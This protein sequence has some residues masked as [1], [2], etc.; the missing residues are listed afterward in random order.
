M[1]K[2]P[3]EGLDDSEFPP[4]LSGWEDW[5]R[6]ER[7]AMSGEGFDERGDVSGDIVPLSLSSWPLDSTFSDDKEM[8][9]IEVYDTITL[10]LTV[11]SDVK[12]RRS[13]LLG[14]RLVDVSIDKLCPLFDGFEGVAGL[15]DWSDSGKSPE[16]TTL[17][18]G[19]NG[20]VTVDA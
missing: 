3:G 17:S 7:R 15:A 14:V 16:E 20:A 9:T 10:T 2:N 6:V 18:V 8:V 12:R 1:E 11:P 4:A 5:L 13:V 19:V